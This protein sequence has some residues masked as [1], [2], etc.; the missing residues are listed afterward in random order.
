MLN[1]LKLI[2]QKLKQEK[3][4]KLLKKFGSVEEIKKANIEELTKVDGITEKLAKKIKET[5]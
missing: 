5:L 1:L 4:K 2:L 3:K